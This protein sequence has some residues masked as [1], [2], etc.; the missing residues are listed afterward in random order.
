MPCVSEG[1]AKSEL[2]EDCAGISSLGRAGTT[3]VL[4]GSYDGR[5]SGGI[6]PEKASFCGEM[7]LGFGN[8]PWSLVWDNTAGDC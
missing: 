1:G 6:R 3:S 8:V 7:D 5:V 4:A 2:G